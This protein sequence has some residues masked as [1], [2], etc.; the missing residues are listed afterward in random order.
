MLNADV[1]LAVSL[2]QT[3]ARSVLPPGSLSENDLGFLPGL[4]E[5]KGRVAADGPPPAG[6]QKDDEGLRAALADP[7][8]K[9][10]QRPIPK[11]GCAALGKRDSFQRHVGE[12]LMLWH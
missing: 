3:V 7:N 9:M 12:R 2:P 10:L 6:A 1:E 4:G 8:P 5:G 11:G